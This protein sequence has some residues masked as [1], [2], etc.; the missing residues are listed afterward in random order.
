MMNWNG[1]GISVME[2]SHRSRHFISI[3]EKARDDL[4]QLLEVPEH[5]TIFFL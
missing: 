1:T 2:M 3:A 4:R 5:F